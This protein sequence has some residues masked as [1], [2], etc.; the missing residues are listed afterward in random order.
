MILHLKRF[1]FDLEFFVKY[2]INDKVTFPFELDM[3]PYTA[4]GI[5]ATERAQAA[6]AAASVSPAAA[7][8]VRT[9]FRFLFVCMCFCS[10]LLLVF[11][12]VWFLEKGAREI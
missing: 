5:A 12:L 4:D 1:E 9:R 10:Y 6:A 7:P 11:G 8:T 3:A 2:K